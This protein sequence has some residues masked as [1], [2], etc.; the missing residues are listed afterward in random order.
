MSRSTQSMWNILRG[1]ATIKIEG[2]QAVGLVSRLASEG[3]SLW[4]VSRSGED[5][6]TAC[7]AVR[8]FFRI[9]TAV[10]DAGCRVHVLSRKGM[11]FWLLAFR[12]RP[13]LLW[14]ALL[15]VGVLAVLSQF[16]WKIEVTGCLNL[17][18]DDVMA[19]LELEGVTVGMPV[20]QVEYSGLGN[21]LVTR[22]DG[23]AWAGVTVEGSRVLVTVVEK[24]ALPETEGDESYGS[25]VADRSGVLSSIT[26]YEGTA[27]LKEGDRVDPGDVIVEGRYPDSANGDIRLTQARADVE[28]R[29]WYTARAFC[30][31]EASAPVRTG[32][33]ETVT[34]VR[35][36]PLESQ[37]PSSFSSYDAERVLSCEIRNFFLPVS[38]FTETRYE[39]STQTVQRSAEEQRT[40]A[41]ESAWSRL[42]A[43]IPK[44]AEIVDQK[45]SYSETE[46]GVWAIAV[47]E[48][49]QK[50]G[51]GTSDQTEQIQM[52]NMVLE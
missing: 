8:D 29:V 24:D 41:G 40:L 10:Y 46:T 6:L 31:S 15:F 47:A 23:A 35:T 48:T 32:R 5:E 52:E 3:I 26:V 12:F 7:I 9:R 2:K 39:L 19:A 45:I 16:V 21:R 4:K 1:Y 27:L 36:G 25:I 14:G 17:S 51:T 18:A 11:P 49:R 38:V 13:V 34:I 20:S 30:K 42:T 37:T 33:T 44:D 22:L 50:I 43:Q 28:C